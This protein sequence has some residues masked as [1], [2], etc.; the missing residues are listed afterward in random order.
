[1]NLYVKSYNHVTA[2]S[3]FTGFTPKLKERERERERCLLKYVIIAG[4]KTVKYDRFC[5]FLHI[6]SVFNMKIVL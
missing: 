5:I 2:L 4:D 1:M 3:G 6:F